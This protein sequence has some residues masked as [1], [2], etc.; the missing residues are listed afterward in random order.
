MRKFVVVFAFVFLTLHL[1][2][3]SQKVV[4]INSVDYEKARYLKED[5]KKFL[6]GKTRYPI[7][8]MATNVNFKDNIEGE[9]I[10]SFLINKNGNLA[11]LIL[12]STNANILSDRALEALMKMDNSWSPTKINHIAV[13]KK[14]K[15]IFRF[16]SYLDTE[17]LEYKKLI[18]GFV[19][20]QKYDKAIKLYDEQINNNPFDFELFTERSKLKELVG[21]KTGAILDYNAANDLNNEFM[22]VVNVIV[23]GVTMHQRQLGGGEG[24]L[25][26]QR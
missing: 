23:V 4:K 13:D 26:V 14:Y 5:L 3:Y 10:Y 16:R 6:S 2:V 8:K 20:K 9:V 11:D 24:P 12:E 18:A 19:K 25:W 17:P 1:S 7:I 15:I 21:D 22:S